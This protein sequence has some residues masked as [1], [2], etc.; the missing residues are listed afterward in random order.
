MAREVLTKRRELLK[1]N[2]SYVKQTVKTVAWSVA[3][4][5]PE[6]WTLRKDIDW[7]KVS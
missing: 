1:K 6:T 5:G 7:F 4:D 3:L 2:S